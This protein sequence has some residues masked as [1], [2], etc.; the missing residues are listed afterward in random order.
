M[1]MLI[2][3]LISRLKNVSVINSSLIIVADCWEG[4][5][6][7]YWVSCMTGISKEIPFYFAHLPIKL[8]HLIVKKYTH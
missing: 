7:P 3:L 8:N 1:Y 2:I 4:V 5:G 6:R